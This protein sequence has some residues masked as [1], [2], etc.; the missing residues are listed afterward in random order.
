MKISEKKEH[1]SKIESQIKELSVIYN[2][3]LEEIKNAN[4]YVSFCLSIE[5]LRIYQHIRILYARIQ[6]VIAIPDP[7]RKQ[8]SSNN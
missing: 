4:K 2:S 7:L 5:N 6:M 1:I 3:N 8:T